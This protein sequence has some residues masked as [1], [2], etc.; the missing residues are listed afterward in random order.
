ML[1]KADIAPQSPWWDSAWFNRKPRHHGSDADIGSLWTW[2]G[3]INFVQW[4][5]VN[6]IFAYFIVCC[7]HQLAVLQTHCEARDN[8]LLCLKQFHKESTDMSFGSFTSHACPSR[9]FVHLS[10]HQGASADEPS[11]RNS[12]WKTT[13]TMS[14]PQS[15]GVWKKATAQRS[16]SPFSI[17]KQ[18]MQ[19]QVLLLVVVCCNLYRTLEFS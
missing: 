3:S 7:A 19:G 5:T 12:G 8:Y 13:F 14:T 11:M 18:Q 16:A 1:Y 10:H 15:K 4:C 2:M 9:I 17:L 6:P